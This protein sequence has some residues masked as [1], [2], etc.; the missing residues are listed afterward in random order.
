M[1]SIKILTV[2][3]IPIRM[4][5]T[6]PLILIL[7]AVQFSIGQASWVQGAAFGVVATL[8][9]FVGVVLHE[10]AHSLVAVG[11][12]SRVKEIVLLHLGGGAQMERIP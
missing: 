12:G 7:A 10:L 5:I 4:H 11:F 3:G 2:R 8:L 6:F 9:L 1:S